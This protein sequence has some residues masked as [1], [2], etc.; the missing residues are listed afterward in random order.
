MVNTIYQKS[1]SALMKRPFR[2]WGISLLGALLCYLAG[3][4]F[5]GILAVG[6]AIGWAIDVSLALIFL[7][8]YKTGEEPHASDLF[9]TFNK[10]QFLRVV[11]GMAWMQLWILIWA[12]I[13]VVGII[14]AC[15]RTYEYRFVPYILATRDDVKPTDALRISKEETMGYKGKMFWA[16]VIPVLFWLAVV[17]VFS[18]L[19]AIPYLGTLFKLILF[20]FHV[21]FVL[22]L[23]LFYGLQHAAFYV[24]I[25]D[26]PAAPQQNVPAAPPVIPAPAAPKA[27]ETPAAPAA[28]AAEE[29]P[30][31]P[32]TPETPAVPE[33]P[34]AEE[35]DHPKVCPV[36][37]MPVQLDERFCTSCGHK[38]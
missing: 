33:E 37:G 2:L 20:L 35:A 29:A 4:G 6:L 21:F 23:N 13:P 27:P 16:D 31:A 24:E 18:L 17:L 30:S 34:K 8:T 12:L 38:L 19:G 5:A 32:E 9:R 14:F 15:I 3:I 11:G 26:A 10:A 28:P 22:F 7:H 36:C 25:H 1:F